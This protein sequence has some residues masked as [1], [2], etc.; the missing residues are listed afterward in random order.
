MTLKKK[1]LKKWVMVGLFTTVV[2]GLTGCSNSESEQATTFGVEDLPQWVR[3]MTSDED[4]ELFFD[5]LEPEELEL[6]FTEGI[7]AMN[8][9][10]VAPEG[11]GHQMFVSPP[12]GEGGCAG[13]TRWTE[14]GVE[15]V[16]LEDLLE[17]DDIDDETRRLIQEVLDDEN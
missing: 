3:E 8:E 7:G 10:P 15:C 5:T 2:L 13:T 6:F 1:G 16:D 4:W 14:N 11:S 17:S 12:G 9:P